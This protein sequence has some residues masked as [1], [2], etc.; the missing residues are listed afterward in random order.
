MNSALEYAPLS[1]TNTTKQEGMRLIYLMGASGSGKDT[2][3]RHLR[4]ML[5]TGEP[6]LVAHRYITRASSPDE[7]SISLSESEFKR[8]IELGCFALHWHSHNLYYGIGIEVDTWLN[9]NAVVIINGSRKHL[10]NAY[11][12]YPK[13]QAIEVTASAETLAQRLTLRGRETA[14]QI[15]SRLKKAQEVYAV[16][17]ECT[18]TS[19]PNNTHPDDAAQ[20]LYAKATQLL[21]I[22]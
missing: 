14:E 16:P 21:A 7:A 5:Q 15:Q 22:S 11:A 2:L 1:I 9:S 4:A 3:L 13:L 20:R 17:A 10:A 18:I 12:R 6:I 8:R 19:L